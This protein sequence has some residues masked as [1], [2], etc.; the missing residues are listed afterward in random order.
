M[1]VPAEHHEGAVE[2]GERRGVAEPREQRVGIGDHGRIGQAGQIGQAG[3]GLAHA[4]HLLAR[5]GPL[6][7][8]TP[9][10][11][12]AGS[13]AEQARAI[14]RST[15]ARSAAN[16]W[17]RHGR[18]AA[19]SVARSIAARSAT[20]A[21]VARAVGAEQAASGQPGGGGGPLLVGPAAQRLHDLPRQVDS[22]PQ[23]VGL[24]AVDIR[25]HQRRE[26][27]LAPMLAEER[28]AVPQPRDGI[29]RYGQRRVRAGEHPAGA[30]QAG[31]RRRQHVGRRGH[32]IAQAVQQPPQRGDRARLPGPHRLVR[33]DQLPDTGNGPA[34]G[35]RSEREERC[36][37]WC[38]RHRAER[39]RPAGEVA[40]PEAAKPGGLERR[41]GL[42][43]EIR[44]R[45]HR[46][47]QCPHPPGD[48][49]GAH[50]GSRLC[51]TGTIRQR[52][53]LIRP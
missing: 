40:A 9:T 23:H 28:G 52:I 31:C 30:V 41:P 43:G 34:D 24:A 26:V 22:R 51:R 50:N 8:G 36:G 49:V 45:V 42:R 21:P 10:G 11:F 2:L 27:S 25:G 38:R 20:P 16:S 7:T 32:R 13:S 33:R 19:T 37:D 39:S 3:P 18:A 29:V 53:W 46:L 5:P 12:S 6:R 4:G 14:G 44:H 1:L 17:S 35:R 47:K 48:L 15:S